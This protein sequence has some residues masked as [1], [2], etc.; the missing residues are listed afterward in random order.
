MSDLLLIK[1]FPS[2][3]QGPQ[4]KGLWN[5]EK[6]LL[7]APVVTMYGK[8]IRVSGQNDTRG[9]ISEFLWKHSREALPSL[10]AASWGQ[11][12]HI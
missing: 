11:A 12:F 8:R 3:E 10:R 6:V 9:G 4:G 5:S 1:K 7:P 2:G